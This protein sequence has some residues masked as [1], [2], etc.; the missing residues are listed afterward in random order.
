MSSFKSQRAVEY[1][2]KRPLGEGSF[3]T[4]YKALR[5][6]P[7]FDIEQTIAL[8]ILKSEIAVEDWK[9]EIAALAAVTSRHCARILGWDLIENRPAL[10]LEWIDGITLAEWTFSSLATD[11]ALIDE[12]CTQIYQGLR[13]MHSKE[14]IHGDLSLENVM[15]DREGTLKILDFSRN[16]EGLCTPEFAAPE[17]LSGG[18]ISSASDLYSL[19]RI[20]ECLQRRRGEK[21]DATTQGLCSAE[22]DRR[23]LRY[24]FPASEIEREVARR[25]LAEQVH[26]IQQQK[27]QPLSMKL[28]TQMLKLCTSSGY[29]FRAATVLMT[30]ASLSLGNASSDNRP[31]FIAVKTRNWVQVWIDDQPGRYA[32][33]E[34]ELPSNRGYRIRW[35]TAKSQGERTLTLEPGQ[36]M[37]VNDSFFLEE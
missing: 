29:F 37:V 25:T 27:N 9:N 3:S 1:K 32:P 10:I 15:I 17:V 19:G 2:L 31:G 35:R 23:E 8:K 14:L 20:R 24:F 12:I 7:Q 16:R 5:R 26:Q 13:D 22:V 6:D 36:N 34:K 28:S 33:F 21:V 30:L 4:V 18:S 11:Q